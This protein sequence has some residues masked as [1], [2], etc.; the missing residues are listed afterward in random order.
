MRQ[1]EKPRLQIENSRAKV[2][3]KYTRGRPKAHTNLPSPSPELS[4]PSIPSKHQRILFDSGSPRAHEAP[5]PKKVRLL[6]SAF[7]SGTVS[8]G[9][10][11]DVQKKMKTSIPCEVAFGKAKPR[12]HKSVAYDTA[13]APGSYE[14]LPFFG[15]SGYALDSTSNAQMLL[16]LSVL[17]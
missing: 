13:P 3:V 11:V 4:S 17:E 2:A 14:A 15:R 16:D 6:S 10:G 7:V 12:K 5:F 8:G 9:T 1:P